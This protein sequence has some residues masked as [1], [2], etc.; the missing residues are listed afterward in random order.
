MPSILLG[1]E[2]PRTL[3]ATARHAA[4]LARGGLAHAAESMAA[5]GAARWPLDPEVVACATELAPVADRRYW[6]AL[7]KALSR[8]PPSAQAEAALAAQ[9]GPDDL[10]ALCT[11]VLPLCATENGVAWLAALWPVLL[12]HP[13]PDAHALAREAIAQTDLTRWPQLAERLRAELDLLD[14]TIDESVL[15]TLSTP[16]FA[17]WRSVLEAIR[18]ADPAR[19]ITQLGSLGW[20]VNLLHVLHGLTHPITPAPDTSSVAICLYTWNKADLLE[21]TLDSL[22]ASNVGEAPIFV[23]DNGSTD[24]TPEL[25]ARYAQAHPRLT[26][27]TLPVN[28]GAPGA[29]NWLLAL[30]EVRAL[31]YACFVDDDVLLPPGWLQQLLGAAHTSGAAT[32]GVRVCAT[33]PPT[34]LQSADYNLLPPQPALFESAPATHVNLFEN[35]TGQPDMG[36]HAYARPCAHVSGCCHLLRLDKHEPGFDIRF[37]PTQF[38]DLDRD[39]KLLA[40]HAQ[41]FVHNCHAYYE[42][43]IRIGHVQHSS[44]ARATT[45]AQHGQIA[46]ART[47]LEANHPADTM[48]TLF[49]TNLELLRNHTQTILNDL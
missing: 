33:T 44:L 9:T 40:A 16:G 27:V 36:L 25:L 12:T 17:Q 5:W 48:H 7:S 21:Q 38:D 20:N 14:E 23:L 43:R 13:A 24:H 18:T 39:L 42:G 2:E 49:S 37:S 29:R 26:P 6:A 32:V 30:P 22:L 8:R 46:G 19:M 1:A 47:K 35:A 3:V 41:D 4:R 10:R 45:R 34:L 11:D 31:R 28:I 15:A